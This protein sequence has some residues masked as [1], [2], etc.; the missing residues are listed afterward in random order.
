MQNA[1]SRRIANLSSNLP[2]KPDAKQ[3]KSELLDL[4]KDCQ[5]LPEQKFLLRVTARSMT[6][7]VKRVFGPLSMIFPLTETGRRHVFLAVLAR[8]DADGTLDSLPEGERAGLLERLLTRRNADLI[9]AAYGSNPPG[10]LR[11]VTRLGDVA[12][13]KRFYLDLHQLLCEG[14]ALAAPLIAATGRE[15]I[16]DELLDMLMHLP[17]V[18]EA[19]TVADRFPDRGRLETFLLIYQTLTGQNDL[20]AEHIARMSKG[21]TPDRI[22]EQLY[23]SRPF[24]EPVLPVHPEFSH[25]ADGYTLIDTA[26]R[27]RNCLRN[28]V[29]EALR[30]E[31]Q[32]YIWRKP[33]Q[34]D[35]VFEICKDAP[36]GWYLSEARHEKNA[37]LNS[38]MSA[39]LCQ[40]LA[41][42]GIT[43]SNSMEQLTRPF[44]DGENEFEDLADF[45]GD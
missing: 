3:L 1:L 12:R 25:I 41:D 26:K 18:P 7:L 33:G 42:F 30:G 22:I 45:L 6:P 23:L 28:Y 40:S 11:L 32:Y 8:L 39:D 37:K 14:P 21:E 44:L 35:V 15:P 19:V 38:A 10:F 20:L 27:F 16:T 17:R 9:T 43:R 34:P 36:F 31:R 29:A 2:A 24:P 4:A 13:G 5:V